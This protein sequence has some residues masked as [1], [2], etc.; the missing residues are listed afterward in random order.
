MIN[1]KKLI[2]GTL[3]YL[4]GQTLVWY[5]ING[6]FISEWVKERPWLMSF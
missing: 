3:L 1:F 6:Q 4:V 2:I 5:Q